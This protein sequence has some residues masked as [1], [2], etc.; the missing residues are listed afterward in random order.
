MN[1]TN[2]YLKIIIMETLKD[3][4]GDNGEVDDR[5]NINNLFEF[6]TERHRLVL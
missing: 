3:K 1:C 4:L 2:D 6:E 5:F